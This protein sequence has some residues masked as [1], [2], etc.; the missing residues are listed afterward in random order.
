MEGIE[1]SLLKETWK[2]MWQN[3]NAYYTSAACTVFFV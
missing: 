3:S 1:F 2:Q